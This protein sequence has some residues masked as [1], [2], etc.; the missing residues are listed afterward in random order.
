MGADEINLLG[1]NV[2]QEHLGEGLESAEGME[3]WMGMGDVPGMQG[4]EGGAEHVEV[5]DMHCTSN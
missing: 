4:W 2:Q 5:L 1:E 3:R